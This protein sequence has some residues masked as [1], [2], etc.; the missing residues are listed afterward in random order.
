MIMFLDYI[1]VTQQIAYSLGEAFGNMVPKNINQMIFQNN[2]ITDLELK[3]I[4]HGMNEMCGLKVLALI[5]N[6]LGPQAIY[7]LNEMLE[8]NSL[9]TIKKLFF[10]DTFYVP[11]G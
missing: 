2:D 8:K 7:Q 9:G 3:S 4:F 11:T 6:G 1:K 5:Q 10:K